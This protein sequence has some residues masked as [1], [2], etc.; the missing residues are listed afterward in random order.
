MLCGFAGGVRG[1]VSEEKKVQ[2]V[3]VQLKINGEL[4][5]GLQERIEY[6]I[7]QVGE[8]ILI[9]QPLSL[10]EANQ[11]TVK[12]AIVKVFTKVLAGFKID[13]VALALNEHTKILIGLTPIPPLIAEIRLKTEIKNLQ[14][15]IIEFA[16]E[17]SQKIEDELNQ[18]FSGLPVASVSWAED[19][20]GLVV[21]YLIER[22]FPG[23]KSKFVIEPGTVTNINLTL[24]PVEPVVTEVE[25]VYASSTIPPWL[26]ASKVKPYEE[27]FALIKGV[28]VEFLQHYQSRLEKVL[29][30]YLNGFPELT[31]LGLTT[32]LRITPG[33]K[34]QVELTIDSKHWR[35]GVEARFFT[36]DDD[37]YTNIQGYLGYLI[38]DYEIFAKGILGETPGGNLKLGIKAPLASNLSGGLEYAP[39]DRFN[40]V[41]F[42]YRFERGDYL[43]LKLGLDGAPNEALIGIYLNKHLNFELAQYE[44]KFGIQLMYHLW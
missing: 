5:D 16:D 13:S 8:K 1:A 3:E 23:F 35:T 40:N 44:K 33:G 2:S 14:P 19:I 11:E 18:V 43:D 39:E 24:E 9:S 41:W 42:H 26:I 28:P 12:S 32:R 30:S 34:T 20:F 31:K 27:K 21:D 15:E 6:S 29:T 38:K 7:S 22:E 36:G 25:A 4:Y 17:I 37:A 10:L